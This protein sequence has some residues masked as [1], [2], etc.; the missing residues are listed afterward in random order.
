[1]S[2]L[3]FVD[4]SRKGTVVASIFKKENGALSIAFNGQYKEN[5]KYVTAPKGKKLIDVE[6]G[7]NM[8]AVPNNRKEAGDKRPDFIVY[9]YPS[10]E[11][12]SKVEA[13]EETK[14]A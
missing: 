3:H 14:E 5:G 7:D 2:K 1:M 11:E 13:P 8:Y 6:Y 9:A 4:D 12:P 10:D